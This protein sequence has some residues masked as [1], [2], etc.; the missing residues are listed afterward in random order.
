[1]SDYQAVK[2]GSAL[3]PYYELRGPGLG[4]YGSHI[5]V[6]LTVHPEA[7]AERLASLLA[8]AFQAGRQAKAREIRLALNVPEDR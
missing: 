5:G 4:Y 7:E 2:T 8:K 6:H 3:G 1:M